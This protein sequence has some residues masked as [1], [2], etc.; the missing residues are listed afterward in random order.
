[1]DPALPPVDAT[2]M[3]AVLTRDL[4]Q[5]LKTGALAPETMAGVSIGVLRDGVSR[6]FAF[7]TAKPDSLY[8]IGSITKTFTGLVLAQM[9]AQGKVALNDPVRKLLPQDALAAPNGTEITLLDLV[10]QHSG[11]PRMPDNLHPADRYN[12]YAD[13]RPADL[14]SFLRQHGLQKPADAGYL[15]SN[16]GV[17][18]L[19]QA[20]ADRAGTSYG[21]L[22][23]R[24]VLL[25]LRMRDTHLT[26]SPAQQTRV[27]Q[28]YDANHKP[29]H[30]WES[31]ALAGAGA[32]RSTAAD[33][34]VYLDA[35]LH[36]D[37]LPSGAE[38]Y[39]E[40]R[41]L[42]AALDQS[43]VLRDD[44][45]RNT[46]IAFA[47]MF[48]EQAQIFWH[49]GAT[50]GYSSFAFFNPKDDFAAVVLFNT[51]PGRGT[52][53]ADMLGAHILQR[54]TGMPAISLSSGH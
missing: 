19:G 17:G 45:D 52:P 50:A 37:H 6:V 18:L 39:R 47:W 24:E 7:G 44:V 51:A 33:M 48:V 54:F 13:Y 21:D 22:V 20:L 34:L 38:K 23:R 1:L 31:D 9:I 27:I 28:G 42:S 14:Y 15:Y 35:N 16:L 41:T 12:P 11:L 5:A 43:H 40:G 30:S 49:N 10:T 8:E 46:R 3:Q 2:G 29:A 25:P 32:I 53:F 26:L 4:E 36:P